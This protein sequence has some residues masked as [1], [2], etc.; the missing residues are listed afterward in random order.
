[1]DAIDLI[2]RYIEPDPCKGGADEVRLKPYGQHVWAIIGDYLAH[3]NP[4]ETAR[5]YD[6]PVEAVVAAVAYYQ[7]H[8]A[9]IDNRLW[10]N[11]PDFEKEWVR[12]LASDGCVPEDGNLILQYIEPDRR[13][14]ADNVRLKPYGQ[15]VWV[16]IGD[17][18]AH[19]DL[20]KTAQTHNI[21]A[22]AVKAAIAYYQHFKEVID[23]RLMANTA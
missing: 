23:N 21:P 7:R 13:P 12:Q 8:Q 18:L 14:G 19:G 17:Y 20:H 4:H 11:D 15:H 10:A 5:A 22:E 3:H 9:V 16:I 2:S 6:I 1:M